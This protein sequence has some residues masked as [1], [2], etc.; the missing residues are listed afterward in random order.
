MRDPSTFEVYGSID[1][2]GQCC[3]TLMQLDC[4]VSERGEPYRS[5]KSCIAI[6]EQD[7]EVSRARIHLL[8]LT[9]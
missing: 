8:S 9:H 2:R 4:V 5:Y 1:Q 3:M 6:L 7:P